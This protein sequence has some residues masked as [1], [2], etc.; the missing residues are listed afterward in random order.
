M[1]V[2]DEKFVEKILEDE[3]IEFLED[4]AILSGFLQTDKKCKEL[5][6]NNLE[7]IHL[8]FQ[9]YLSAYY[10]SNL[11]REKIKEVIR[12][13][14][15]YPHMQIFFMFLA[16]LIDDKNFLIKEVKSEPRDILGFYEILFLMSLLSQIKPQELDKELF[17]KFRK[18]LFKWLDFTIR[19]KIQYEKL[20]R[21]LF[22]IKEYAKIDNEIINTFINIIKNKNIDTWIKKDLAETFANIVRDDEWFIDSLIN[23]I[24][25]ENI[26]SD[27]RSKVS[28][29]LGKI[30]RNDNWFTNQLI[31]IVKN[32]NIDTWIRVE[33]AETLANIKG[34]DDLVVNILIDFIKNKS[35]NS[36]IRKYIAGILATIE[37]NDDKITNS[38][39]DFIFTLSIDEVISSIIYKDILAFLIQE[40][41]NA[42]NEKIV[43]FI[44]DIINNKNIEI[45]FRGEFSRELVKLDIENKKVYDA[46]IKFI[47]NESN[48]DV[49]RVWVAE[50]IAKKKKKNKRIIKTL[51]EFIKNEKINQYYRFEVAQTLYNTGIRNSLIKKILSSYETKKTAR[52]KK[53]KPKFNDNIDIIVIS[54]FKDRLI[55]LLEKIKKRQNNL[56]FI[57]NLNTLKYFVEEASVKSNKKDK[58][59]INIIVE[60]LNKKQIYPDEKIEITAILLF[61]NLIEADDK[62][63][64]LFLNL[65]KNANYYYKSSLHSNF[66]KIIAKTL[67]EIGIKNN[68]NKEA[69]IGFIK[70]EKIRIEFKQEI[71]EVFIKKNNS[72]IYF[73]VNLIKKISIEKSIKITIVNLISKNLTIETYN[74]LEITNKDKEFT[75]IFAKHKNTRI[76]IEAF[77]ENVVDLDFMFLHGTYRI[78]PFYLKENNVLH[79][80]F[81]GKELK[82]REVS[83]KEIKEALE[84]IGLTDYQA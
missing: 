22:L 40:Y 79:T 12:D 44:V 57:E 73:L 80:I 9:E 63:F 81:E 43:N 29:V 84:K 74:A 61:L 13:Y 68:N 16:G 5:L 24:K 7:F 69:L 45:Q 42:N 67:A 21:N 33:I 19:E 52:L 62:L 1:K 66:T 71:L 10:V 53:F 8:T 76:I 47:R 60:I 34:N 64:A 41:I 27:I 50:E 35:I 38:L 78:L 49:C 51:L 36:N 20:L 17:E 83:K 77:K 65:F 56:T 2:F 3:E 54:F 58:K 59:I 39:V 14:K 4:K 23:L 37:R 30:R 70:D 15:F 6:D 18:N 32:E 25:D 75:H 28:E 11:D 46:I 72:F 31:C 48:L 55:S 26:D 82:G